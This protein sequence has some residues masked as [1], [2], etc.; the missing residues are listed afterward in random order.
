VV[1]P[2]AGCKAPPAVPSHAS[3]SA[4]EALRNSVQLAISGCA[5]RIEALNRRQARLN[6]QIAAGDARVQQERELLAGLA[7]DLYRQPSLLVALT[8]SHSLG[9]FFT[10][11]SDLQSAGARAQALTNQL[12]ADQAQLRSDRAS[13]EAAIGEEASARASLAQSS[14]RLQQLIDAALAEYPAAA[15]A[16]FVPVGPA[17]IIADIEKA[18]S[19]LGQ[20]AVNW[21]LRVAKC[22]SGY[23]P[24]AVNPYSGTE[25]LFQFMPSTWRSTPYGSHNVFDPWYNSLGAAWLYHRD[26]PSQ[27]QCG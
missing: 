15:P 16:I 4:L 19:P 2:A 7:R 20:T 21:G 3:L 22:E 8:S 14:A 5:A 25:G 23:N 26:G 18:F 13:V 1:V 10:R 9:D 12:N 17:A 24:N 27:W 6:A 11:V